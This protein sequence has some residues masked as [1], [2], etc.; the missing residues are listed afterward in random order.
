MTSALHTQSALNKFVLLLTL[1]FNHILRAY[2]L[3][4]VQVNTL[5][6]I[7]NVSRKRDLFSLFNSNLH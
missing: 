6:Y 1:F 7:F 5:W 4:K 3:K 2:T